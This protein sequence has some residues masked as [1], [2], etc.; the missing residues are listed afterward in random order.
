MDNREI[1]FITNYLLVE[2]K[3]K[4]KLIRDLYTENNILK[5]KR[6]FL[7]SDKLMITGKLLRRKIVDLRDISFKKHPI[8]KY[9][10]YKNML[11]EFSKI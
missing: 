7:L 1:N 4:D 2:S 8:K 10:A 6:E 11:D 9:K 5:R 3:E